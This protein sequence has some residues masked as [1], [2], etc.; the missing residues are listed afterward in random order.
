MHA[1]S[2]SCTFSFRREIWIH[3]VVVRL[4]GLIKSLDYYC[5]L[6]QFHMS[7]LHP[8]RGD[9]EPVKLGYTALG[10]RNKGIEAKCFLLGPPSGD[11]GLEKK[12]MDPGGQQAACTADVDDRHLV[13]T[14]ETIFED[15]RLLRRD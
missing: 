5:L 4:L 2:L 8:G 7:T 9:L 6:L 11:V 14:V 1:L 3:G 15:Q 10:L 12:W 13:F